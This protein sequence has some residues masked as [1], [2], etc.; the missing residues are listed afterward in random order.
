MTPPLSIVVPTYNRAPQLARLLEA[1]ERQSAIDEFEVIVVDDGSGDDTA[2][3]LSVTRGYPLS[4]IHQPNA[5][6]AAARNAAEFRALQGD[7]EQRGV[8]VESKGF[9]T[10]RAP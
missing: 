9:S 10:K 1:L 8:Y 4:A 6:P 2:G 5:G 7:S 3:V